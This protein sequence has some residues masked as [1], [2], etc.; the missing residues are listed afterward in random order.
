MDNMFFIK[1]RVCKLAFGALAVMMAYLLPNVTH[2]ALISIDDANYGINSLTFDTDTN[3]EWLDITLTINRSYN[4]IKKELGIG[5][6]YEGF[7]YASQSEIETL[8]ANE[9]IFDYSNTYVSENYEPIKGLIPYLGATASSDITAFTIGIYEGLTL[10]GYQRTASL[11][12]RDDIFAGKANLTFNGVTQDFKGTSHGS[13]LLRT[14]SVP[15][16][17]TLILFIIG[18]FLI[19]VQENITRRIYGSSNF[20]V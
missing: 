18:L 2:A 17:P 20:K 16:P 10:G 14:V 1:R 3:L 11:Q 19:F 15:L 8:W 12:Y 5:G 4:E 13:Y 6:E 9:G 7:R